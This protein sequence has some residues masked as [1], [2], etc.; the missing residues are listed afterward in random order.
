MRKYARH[1]I[2]L[3]ESLEEAH[4]EGENAETLRSKREVQVRT[5][6]NA[7]RWAHFVNMGL[8]TWLITQPL[9]INVQEPG[10][11]ITEMV[12]GLALL[13]S[14]LLRCLG[15]PL[16]LAGPVPESVLW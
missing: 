8:A 14:S 4:R 3:P 15:R 2:A 1:G 16:G 5:E 13:V 11:R 12:L 7:N 10:L 6:H 9:L